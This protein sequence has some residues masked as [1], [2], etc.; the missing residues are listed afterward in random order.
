MGSVVCGR[1]CPFN[2][3]M[4]C[5]KGIVLLNQLGQ[6]DEHWGK[7]GNPITM[8]DLTI[9]NIDE[10]LKRYSEKI[11]KNVENNETKE[12]KSKNIRQTDAL[13]GIS[14]RNVKAVFNPELLK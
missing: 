7:I 2:R 12:E 5:G 8:R 6:C 11:V 9:E 3:G 10:Y 14:S 4:Y 1:P 13:I